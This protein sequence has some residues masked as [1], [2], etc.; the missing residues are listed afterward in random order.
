M[1]NSIL[2]RSLNQWHHIALMVFLCLSLNSVAQNTEVNVPSS[3][4]NY[5]TMSAGQT[6]T[7][8]D[9]GGTSNYP[10]NCNGSLVITGPAFSIFTISGS[11]NTEN[12]F[13]RIN[14]TDGSSPTQSY[15]S[16]GSLVDTTETNMLTIH[17]SS[18]ASVT[19]SGFSF[20]ITCIQLCTYIHDIV[21]YTSF[22]SATISWQDSSNA[23]QWTVSYG[24]SASNLNNQLTVDTTMVTINNLATAT[25]YYYQISSNI[26][27]SNSL[28][29]S[30]QKVFK[31]QCDGIDLCQDFTDLTSCKVTCYYGTFENPELH[32]GQVNGRH[33]VIT[34]N[35]YDYR[36]YGQLSMIP[37]GESTSIRLGNNS[38]GAQA[39]S[40]IYE[41]RVDTTVYDLLL[42]RYAAVLEN[43]NHTP[44]EQPRFKFDV[45]DASMNPINVN[46]Y[47]A[48]F[49][50]SY[51][52]GWNAGR[53]NVLWKDWTPVAVDLAPM[54][55]QTIYIKLT[56]YDC[57][58]SGHF[59][60]AY[61]TL[62]CTNKVIS[63]TN[64][65]NTV[66]NVFSAPAGFTYRWYR[67]DTP[68]TTLSTTQSLSVTDSG[69]YCC[70]MSMVG[71]TG[72][73]C[74]L[75]MNAIAGYR[76]PYAQFTSNLVDTSTC[77]QGYQFS[78]NSVITSDAEHTQ[79]TNQPCEGSLWDFGDGSTS[80]ERNPLHFFYPGTYQVRLISSL[81]D[82]ACQDTAFY[83]ITVTS[84]CSVSDTIYD[85]ICYGSSLTFFD[86][87]ITDTGC[88]VRDSMFTH[89]TLYLAHEY[90]NSNMV[91]DT[92]VENQLPHTYDSIT[93]TDT[94]TNY[95][96]YHISPHGCIDTTWYNLFV[97]RNINQ[98]FD[99]T[100][101][102]AQLPLEWEG[103]TFNDT[104]HQQLSL[105]G[106]HGE[107]SIV[108]F[109][110]MAW[111]ES[112]A[113]IFDTIV[114][115]QLP[116]TF[117]GETYNNDVYADTVIL[118]DIHGCDS[119]F[120][121][122]LHVWHNVVTYVDS[123]ICDN[124]LPLQ[125]G[126]HILSAAG[127]DST[128]YTGIHGNDS[129]VVLTLTVNPT[130]S[131]TLHESICDGT[132]YNFL[133]QSLTATGVYSD[134]LT[135][136][137]QCDSVINVQL[138][139][140][141][142]Y[143]DIVAERICQGESYMM[144][145]RNFAYTG[146]YH[147]EMLT[148]QGC[149]SIVDLNLTV[150]PTF[151]TPIEIRS[152]DNPWIEYNGQVYDEPG[153]YYVTLHT[154]DGCDSVISLSLIIEMRASA[155]F[156]MEPRVATYEN[157]RIRLSDH[158]QHNYTREWIIDDMIVSNEGI[159]Y[160]DYPLDRDSIPVVLMAINTYGCNDT[161]AKTIYL[162][163]PAIWNANAF[164]PGEATNNLFCIMEDNV[165]TEEVTIYT[166]SGLQVAQFDGLT[167]CWDGTLNGE[168]LPQDVY[169]YLVRYTTKY[170]P[171]NLLSKKGTV[172][173]LR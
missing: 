94:T 98:S 31:T 99:T 166:R 115:N 37:P 104:C 12:G 43:P 165:L 47:S 30:G 27:Y 163:R 57:E 39:E 97:Y 66:A 85:T 158:S 109:T 77:L 102:A 168:P 148:G 3:G 155:E 139:V 136:V 16:M 65:G 121:Y 162:Q 10:N 58:R 161:T 54:H 169:V 61:F 110:V 133:G 73:D 126:A 33:T 122:S 113:V 49:I 48:D 29:S 156:L 117:N 152:C 22:T 44:E 87:V 114:E 131:Q 28:C 157:H 138:T 51:A 160:Y 154:V 172:L 106:Q 151:Q 167:Q 9:P 18:D 8:R 170:E 116:W 129:V 23:T 46:C 150:N 127:V 34:Q 5:Q 119:I 120:E 38:T 24:T 19:R 84:P 55:G 53:S 40:I 111:Y 63:A 76:Y 144:G 20:T 86:T 50:S 32:E 81:S 92:I 79:L 140:H 74:G 25:R 145:G 59:G 82:G 143:Y 147:V 71:A 108:N 142:T 105:I 69:V 153:L 96:I 13:D 1:V 17:F 89:R 4:T 42:L 91:F 107:D 67:E 123:T 70:A 52:L 101:C 118:S 112:Y 125:W 80:T 103:H 21:A 164:T 11:Y 64:C 68:N 60:Y 56:T 26:T 72:S 100:I 171:L 135:T 7:V 95:P 75:V 132:S 88:Y 2:L 45:L 15:T 93:F 173:L 35:D 141:P 128:L 36:T 130:Y 83:S 14:L 146:Q 90:A 6:L 78:N 41:Y 149:D 124:F 62:N 159:V 137:N 134:T